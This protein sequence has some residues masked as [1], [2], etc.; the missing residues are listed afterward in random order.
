MTSISSKTRS[1]RPASQRID[2]L[3][4]FITFLQKNGVRR[5]L[6][7][8]A[9]HGDTFFQVMSCLPAGSTGV[10]V[11]L[12]G[13]KWGTASSRAALQDAAVDLRDQ[14]Y[15]PHLI[16]GNS[17]HKEIK[18]Q[19]YEHGSFDAILIDG[20]HSLEGV[21]ADFWNYSILAPIVALHDIDGHGTRQKTTG[22]LVEVPEFWERL[23]K[24]PGHECVEIIGA[25]RGM[26][27]GVVFK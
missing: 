23:K 9:R 10:A 16:F 25:E 17:R 11:D 20:D 6:E 26:G 15:K 3:A 21:S 12:P 4:E 5:Y 13:G 22:D 18:R 8:G 14:G 24:L 19:V 27:I 7:I 1:G 2:E